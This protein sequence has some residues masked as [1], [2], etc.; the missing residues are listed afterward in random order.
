M[1]VEQC[2]R[3]G[4]NALRDNRSLIIPGHVNRIMNAVVPAFVVRSLMARMFGKVLGGKA[5][6][7]TDVK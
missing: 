2:V 3:E 6:A 1:T 4:L 7:G 5:L